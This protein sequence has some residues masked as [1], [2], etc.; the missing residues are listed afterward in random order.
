M[1][2]RRG[3]RDCRVTN[4]NVSYQTSKTS[5]GLRSSLPNNSQR[6]RCDPQ[7]CPRRL[8]PSFSSSSS[9]SRV[10][11]RAPH[12]P[13]LCQ[14]P[15]CRFH[16]GAG[17]LAPSQS[18]AGVYATSWLDSHACSCPALCRCVLCCCCACFGIICVLLCRACS[19]GAWVWLGCASA[20][21]GSGRP[22]RHSKALF[23][24]LLS[25]RESVRLLRSHPLI[26]LLV[27]R[28]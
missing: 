7:R 24:G 16:A 28:I 6:T 11:L 22:K 18:F 25:W 3:P 13:R 20:A 14:D 27:K 23:L 15:R 9:L 2:L 21:A 17:L 19:S 1:S 10:S 4:G 8:P 12:S 26:A 5:D